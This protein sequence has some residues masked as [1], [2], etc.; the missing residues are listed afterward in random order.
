MVYAFSVRLT[1]PHFTVYSSSLPPGAYPEWPFG[2]DLTVASF[3]VVCE[4]RIGTCL[5]DP[6]TPSAMTTFCPAIQPRLLLLEF[7]ERREKTLGGVQV[8]SSQVPH[9]TLDKRRTVYP[10]SIFLETQIA[11]RHSA[12]PN[13]TLPIT[14]A[15]GAICNLCRKLPAKLRPTRA[16]RAA[17]QRARP[18]R[19]SD[20]QCSKGLHLMLNG[21]N[22][23]AIIDLQGANHPPDLRSAFQSTSRPCGRRQ[24][25]IPHADMVTE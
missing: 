11:A 18:L 14:Q 2:Q 20:P 4:A 9:E 19:R 7:P 6:L 13:S 5:V 16:A 12:S 3:I 24:R 23:L 22:R 25:Q 15:A 17:F 1:G 8:V 10:I 21:G